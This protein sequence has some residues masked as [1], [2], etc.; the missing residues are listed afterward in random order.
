MHSITLTTSEGKWRLFVA[1][2]ADESFQRFSERIWGRDSY[3]CQFCG[4]QAKQYQEVVNLDGDYRNNKLI[5]MV[6]A[7]VFCTQCFF[8]ESVGKN[9]YGGG[10][11]IYL[12]ELSQTD[13]NGLCHVLFCA[14]ANATSYH[15]DAQSVYRS[16]KLRSKIVEEKLGEGM[17]S[18][19]LVGRM[20]IDAQIKNRSKVGEDLLK[21][22]RLLPS[23]TTFSKQIETWA[24]AALEEMGSKGA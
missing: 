14:I 23:R 15:S 4:F 13:L 20:L 1:R 12:P 22:L 21:D 24:H 8:I 16:L 17:N 10:L 9:D 3:T 5:N 18:P 7:C 11:L 2:K 6:T 19:A